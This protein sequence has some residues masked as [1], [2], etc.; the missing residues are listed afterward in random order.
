MP[1]SASRPHLS[2]PHPSTPI[3][4][5]MPRRSAICTAC[6]AST[7]PPTAAATCRSEVGRPGAGRTGAVLLPAAPC[8]A[9]AAVG[10]ERSP[11]PAPA[12]SA[13][14]GG[15]PWDVGD[16]QPCLPERGPGQQE[17]HARSPGHHLG[18][19]RA[20]PAAPGAHAP[21]AAPGTGGAAS[22]GA[23]RDW[24]QGAGAANAV[25]PRPHTGCAF[26]GVQGAIDF[27]VKADCSDLGRPPK[28][29]VMPGLTRAMVVRPDGTGALRPASRRC[30][31]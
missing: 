11:R 2:P 3:H 24:R 5:T 27:T 18:R 16:G 14:G 29:Q 8:S 7:C 6:S 12:P 10:P 23:W 19:P 21:R 1:P 13:S 25:A 28:A 17:R 26:P 22:F 15:P 31:C 20:P 30:C 4:N 9:A